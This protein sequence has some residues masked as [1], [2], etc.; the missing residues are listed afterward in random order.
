MTPSFGGLGSGKQSE[1]LDD[2]CPDPYTTAAETVYQESLGFTHLENLG[3]GEPGFYT[4]GEPGF[5]TFG[6]PG[7]YTFEERG[8]Y[9]FGEPA[10]V[11]HI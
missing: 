3:L 7:F 11:L 6:E 10:C 5:Y 1:L 4:F 9:T 8:L 2:L